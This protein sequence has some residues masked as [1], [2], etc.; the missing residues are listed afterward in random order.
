MTQ[1]WLIRAGRAGEREQ[2]ALRNGVSGGGFYEVPDLTNASTR[3]AVHDAVASAFPGAKEGAVQN[4][5]A[6]LWALRGRIVVGDYVVMPLKGSPVLAIGRVT[7][8]YEYRNDQEPSLRHVRPVDWVAPDVS[9]TAVKQDLLYSLGAFL[10]ICEVKR[11]DAVQRISALAATGTD[12]GAR[13]PIGGE[14]KHLPDRDDDSDV[15]DESGAQIDVEQYAFDRLSTHVIETF[16]GHK[17]QSLVAA[18]LE[19][20]GFT[21]KVP[22]EGPDQGVDV[23]A[24]TGPFGLDEPRLVVQVKSEAGAV[25]SPVV[26]QLL[27]AMHTHQ[28]TQGLLVAWGGIKKPAE[29]L[30]ANQYFRV[31]VWSSKELLEAIFRNYDRLSE[32]IRS[33]LPLKR[34]WTLVEEAG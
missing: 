26:Q 2:W 3:E 5:A 10:T 32:E 31:R 33:E 16:A 21:C 28:T 14:Q 13:T 1:A 30:L 9:R 23:L 24:G 4:F 6:Q 29:Q 34:I 19:A 17:M 20:E 15:S 11:N 27:G 22:P 25:G 8:P 18:V 12:P 7:G